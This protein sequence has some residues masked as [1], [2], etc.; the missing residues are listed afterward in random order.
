MNID[1]GVSFNPETKKVFYNA[2][3]NGCVD[4]KNYTTESIQLSNGLN[5][6]V[7]CIFIRTEVNRNSELS[8]RDVDKDDAIKKYDGNP[9][10]YAL[11]GENNWELF[12]EKQK[13]YIYK[14]AQSNLRKILTKMDIQTAILTPSKSSINSEIGYMV[15]FFDNSINIISDVMRKLTTQEVWEEISENETFFNYCKSHHLNYK[16]MIDKAY[17]ELSTIKNG[18]YS[19]H[20]IVD[21]QLR[22]A[23]SDSISLIG[24]NEKL[25]DKYNELINDKDV[26]VIDDL[27]RSGSTMKSTMELVISNYSPKSIIG[28][29]LLSS[30]TK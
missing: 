22:N 2:L 18:L 26:M 21:N 12:D 19:S 20:D 23:I 4:T 11:K 29:S 9:L 28:L 1:E 3:V 7:Y 6:I 5:V 10:I 25:I 27:I 14:D 17:K 16:E 15:R 30:R 13:D 8:R 24:I